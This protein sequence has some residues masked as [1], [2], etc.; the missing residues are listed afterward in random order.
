M[1]TPNLPHSIFITLKRSADVTSYLNL[2]TYIS[3]HK[4]GNILVLVLRV[5]I[6][7][8]WFKTYLYTPLKTIIIIIVSDHYMI[9]CNIL[10]SLV[11]NGRPLHIMSLICQRL[12]AMAFLPICLTMISPLSTPALNLIMVLS[13]TNYYNFHTC[14]F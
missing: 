5:I 9:T 10:C 7:L 1:K 2:L 14:S 8:M 12:V 13:D 3:T 11:L 6:T 4:H